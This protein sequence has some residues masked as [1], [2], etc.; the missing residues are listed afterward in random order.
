VRLRHVLQ[1]A[2]ATVGIIAASIG[3]NVYWQYRTARPPALDSIPIYSADVAVPLTDI[4]EPQRANAETQLRNF[5]ATVQ[6]GYRVAD[7]RLLATKG[8]FIWDAVR[9]D[10]GSRLLSTGYILDRNGG[11][12][13]YTMT[14]SAYRRHG[15]RQRFNNDMIMAAGFVKTTLKTATG[16]DVYLYGYFRLTPS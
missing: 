14:Y 5:V 12:I 10:I 13:D 15:L 11:S 7:E 8:R 16:D 2:A 6:P 3:V 1:I 9:H 4:P